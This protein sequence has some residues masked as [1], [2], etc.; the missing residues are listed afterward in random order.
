[1]PHFINVAVFLYC[2]KRE[3]GGG[4]KPMLKKTCGICNSLANALVKAYDFLPNAQKEGGGAVKGVLNKIKKT[5]RLV[6]WGI[7]YRPTDIRTDIMTTQ[8]TSPQ[9]QF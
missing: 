2:S 7:P 5:A 4:V 6:K 9:Y 8:G 3:G 1:M